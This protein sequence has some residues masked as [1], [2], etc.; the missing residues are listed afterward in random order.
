MIAIAL[1]ADPKLRI[2]DEPSTARDVTG[3]AQILE[4]LRTLQRATGM[5]LMLIT[6]DLGVIAE[7]PD[8]VMVLYAGRV[9]ETAPVEP[10]FDAPQQPSTQALLASIPA[11]AHRRDHL[12]P[13]PGKLPAIGPIPPSFPFSTLFRIARHFI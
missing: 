11:L 5:A 10:F 12:L 4:L 2:A 3:Q 8:R 13:L 9:A 1:A 7:I 6:H